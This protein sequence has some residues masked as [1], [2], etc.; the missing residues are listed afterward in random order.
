[1]EPWPPLVIAL[2]FNRFEVYPPHATLTPVGTVRTTGKDAGSHACVDFYM[3]RNIE[4]FQRTCM[5]SAG[6]GK[7]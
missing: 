4:V 5:Q 3:R 2:G 1:M 6:H 7:R